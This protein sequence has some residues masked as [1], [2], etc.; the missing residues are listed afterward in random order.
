MLAAPSWYQVT[1]LLLQ[2]LEHRRIFTKLRVGDQIRIAAD[3][4]IEQYS[5]PMAGGVLPRGFGAFS[6][7]MSRLHWEMSFG[8]YCSV[9]A[10]LQ[11]MGS[12]HPVEWASTS[13]F[14]YH[15]EP[16][17]SI[18]AYLVD[19][20]TESF[21]LLR[22]DHGPQ[23]VDVG[24]D[25][26][27]GT[28]VVLKR[29]ITIGTGAVVAARSVVTHD[30]PPYAIVGGSPARIIRYR[31]PAAMIEH[32]LASS[33]WEYGPDVLQPLG[34]DDP[35]AFLDRLEKA[36]DGSAPLSLA[37]ATGAELI[38]AAEISD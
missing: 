23:P 31:F 16:V 27:I 21:R 15:P 4:R 6:Y 7:S 25:V 30:V 14:S 10:N 5:N 11:I 36:K 1:D 22:A 32:M 20:G 12:R 13:P 38:R 35:G 17:P 9:A 26:W 3:A 37:V 2:V 33:W 8:R 19:R 18:R 34:M 28:D 24:H 29:G